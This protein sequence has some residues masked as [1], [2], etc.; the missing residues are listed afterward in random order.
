MSRFPLLSDEVDI[1]KISISNIINNQNK[2]YCNI[3]YNGNESLYIQ[4]PILKFIEPI[5]NQQNSRNNYKTIYLFLT[6]QDS[7]TYSFIEFINK[8]E[9]FTTTTINNLKQQT[10]NINSL[11][12][13]YES[14][15]NNTQRQ[16][17][18]Y[19]KVSLLDQT[20]IEYNNKNISVDELNKL[21]RKVNLKLIFELNM[22]WL[23]Q[24]KMGIYL[25]PIRIKAIDIIEE[26]I[27]SFRDDD[28]PLHNLL[29]TE[30]DNIHTIINNNFN[31]LNES[32]FKNL[33]SP[34][35]SENPN[36]LDSFINPNE[37]NNVI[38]QDESNLFINPN[39]SNNVIRQESNT[40]I[41]QDESNTVIKLPENIEHIDYQKKL[42]EELFIIDN[43]NKKIEETL[44]D[45]SSSSIRIDKIS[46]KKLSRTNKSSSSFH[47]NITS[48]K[49]SSINKK[50]NNSLK[51]LKKLLDNSDDITS[52]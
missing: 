32:I 44:S 36:E 16:I 48:K 9:K 19:L 47:L 24:T 6:P 21:V 39:E 51:E 49:K 1:S 5:V 31:S 29:Y 25:K 52:E 37:S 35:E 11:I 28:S 42:Q 43:S 46:R 30:V 3:I 15:I 27:I 13:V 23:S 45:K 40:V 14:E 20:K 34:S 8:V 22:I 7:S 33:N 18:M 12:K 10:L 38:R 26:P 4:S 41:R 2:Q 50:Q 17:Y